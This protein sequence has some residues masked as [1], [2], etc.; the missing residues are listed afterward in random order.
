LGYSCT[1]KLKVKGQKKLYK[2]NSNQMKI[3]VTTLISGGKESEAELSSA[4]KNINT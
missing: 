2:A 1:K 3:R 4:T